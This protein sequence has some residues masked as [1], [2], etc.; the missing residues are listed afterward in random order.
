MTT[1]LKLGAKDHDR[2]L[3]LDDFLSAEYEGGWQYELIDG[4]LYV[5]PAPNA[6]LRILETWIL[7]KLYAYSQAHPEVFNFVCWGPRVFIPGRPGVTIPEPDAAAYQD[8]PMDMDF[9]AIRW[10]D[11]NPLLVVEVLSPEDPNKDLVRNSELY[12]QSPSIKEYWVIDGRQNLNQPTLTVHRR[13][14]KR[15]RLI[16]HNPGETYTT[17]LLPGFE[18]IVD[19]RR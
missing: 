8:F 1:L 9:A 18:L 17:K 4:R 6:P 11:H 14:G 3:S 7:F 12:L 15:W 10:Q 5:S 19:P 2:E 13:H 16:S